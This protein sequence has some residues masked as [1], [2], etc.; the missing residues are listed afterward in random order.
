MQAF[1]LNTVRAH[2]KELKHPSEDILAGHQA[3][4]DK[5]VLRSFQSMTNPLRWTKP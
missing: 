5:Y 1:I 4:V 2:F 3:T